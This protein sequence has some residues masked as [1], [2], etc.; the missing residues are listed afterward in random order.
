VANALMKHQ[1]LV[2]GLPEILVMNQVLVP[3]LVRCNDAIGSAARYTAIKDYQ[4]QAELQWGRGESPCDA[5]SDV[6][7]VSK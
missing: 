3:V 4:S 6:W 2:Y 5:P 7:H 1:Y